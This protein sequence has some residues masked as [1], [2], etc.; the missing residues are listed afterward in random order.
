MRPIGAVIATP[1][2]GPTRVPTTLD[3]HREQTY[4]AREG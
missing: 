1:G 3:P 2:D 4:A